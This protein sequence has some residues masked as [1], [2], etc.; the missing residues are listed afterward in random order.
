MP[1]MARGKYFVRRKFYAPP[2]GA[3]PAK[4]VYRPFP[5]G[6]VLRFGWDEVRNRFA[7][8]RY[9]DGLSMFDG[10]QQFS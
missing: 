10:A 4:L 7:M 6:A 5:I 3:A 9:C 1:L 2:L 8:P